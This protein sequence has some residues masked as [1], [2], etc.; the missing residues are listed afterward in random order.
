MTNKQQFQ[1]AKANEILFRGQTSFTARLGTLFP[2]MGFA[3][4][5]KISQRT[6]KFGLQPVMYE[7]IGDNIESKALRSAVAGSLLGAGEVALLPLDALKV[8]AQTNPES[9]HKR[10]ISSILREQKGALYRGAGWTAAQNIP[11]SFAL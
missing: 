2:G 11:G 5:Y 7:A 9:L 6:Y 1:V 10:S 8:K 3:G 4:L